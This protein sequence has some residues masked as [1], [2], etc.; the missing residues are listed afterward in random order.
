MLQLP[1]L[2]FFNCKSFHMH[3]FASKGPSVKVSLLDVKVGLP[4]AGGNDLEETFGLLQ[5]YSGHLSC[6]PV[7]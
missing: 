6:M 2:I 3:D 1:C 7:V 5:S 4:S